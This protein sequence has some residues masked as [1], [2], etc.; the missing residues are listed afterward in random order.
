VGRG[1]FKGF[2]KKKF[3]IFRRRGITKGV[4]AKGLTVLN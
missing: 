2:Y 1:D 3:G 4:I